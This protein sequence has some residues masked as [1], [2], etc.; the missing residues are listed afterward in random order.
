[1][2]E[3]LLRQHADPLVSAMTQGTRLDADQAKRMLPPALDQ[4][5]DAVQGGAGGLDLGALLG[6]GQGAVQALI[7]QLDLGRI[8]SAAGLSEAQVREGVER[9]VP[10]VMGLLQG[11]GGG[12]DGLLSALGAKGGAGALGALGG[13]AGKL[14]GR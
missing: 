12:I 7:G 8:A 6:G 13:V 9:L 1:M 3:Q 10:A 11:Q 2:L 14:F 5:G 4:I